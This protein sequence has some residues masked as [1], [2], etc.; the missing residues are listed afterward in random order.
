MFHLAVLSQYSRLKEADAMGQAS[1]LLSFAFQHVWW[2]I[3]LNYMFFRCRGEAF[4]MDR[5]MDFMAHLLL[6]GVLLLKCSTLS[7]SVEEAWWT[8]CRWQV[9]AGFAFLSRAQVHLSSRRSGPLLYADS[10]RVQVQQSLVESLAFVGTVQWKAKLAQAACLVLCVGLICRFHFLVSFRCFILPSIVWFGCQGLLFVLKCMWH[11]LRAWNLTSISVAKEV[12]TLPDNKFPPTS[13]LLSPFLRRPTWRS[14][15]ILPSLDLPKVFFQKEGCLKEQEHFAFA[16]SGLAVDTPF[17]KKIVIVICLFSGGWGGLHWIEQCDP[18][19]PASVS[20]PAQST[21][22]GFSK[23]VLSLR[24]C[25]DSIGSRTNQAG[26]V[27]SKFRCQ[28]DGWKIAMRACAFLWV[29][30]CLTWAWHWVCS[31]TL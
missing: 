6:G 20:L 21:L 3:I 29:S 8:W 11:R 23:Q 14:T 2:D 13:G 15:H 7:R 1:K 4:L 16:H 10:A 17:W 30:W 26:F 19:Q 22:T 31:Q 9:L 5:A 18:L 28:I 12:V 25:V 27:L 24:N